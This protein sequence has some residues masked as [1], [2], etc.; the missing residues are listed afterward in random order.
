[1]KSSILEDVIDLLPAATV[2][3]AQNDSTIAQALAD[4]FHLHCARVIVA[5]NAPR[6]RTLLLRHPEVRLAVID[7]DLVNPKEVRQLASSF[8]NLTILCTH[9]APYDQMWVAVL[10]AGA[11]EFCHPDDIR[12]ILQAQVT[13]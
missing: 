6:L 4:S 12:S 5:E 13:A 10:D 9:P 8:C 3:I 11:V 2:V 1:M 7:L